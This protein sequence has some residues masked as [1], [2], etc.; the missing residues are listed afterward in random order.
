[1]RLPEAANNAAQLHP[2]RPAPKIAIVLVGVL[3]TT[4]QLGK[5]STYDALLISDQIMLFVVG[6]SLIF[7]QVYIFI[8]A[9]DLISDWGLSQISEKLTISPRR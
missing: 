7:D 5:G 1:M 3:V 2:I 9:L 6:Q 4:L 8:F